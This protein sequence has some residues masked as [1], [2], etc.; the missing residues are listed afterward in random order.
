MGGNTR[1]SGA[2]AK[3]EARRPRYSVVSTR[4]VLEYKRG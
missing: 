2:N 3:E 4:A 1:R